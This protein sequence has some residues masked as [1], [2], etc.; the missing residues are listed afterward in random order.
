MKSADPRRNHLLGL[1]FAFGAGVC[2]SL[3]GWLIKSVSWNPMAI[4]GGRSIIAILLILVVLG[5]PKIT[6]S[7][8]QIGGALA[9]AATVIL[10]VAANKLTTAANAILLQYTGPIYTAFFGAKI[11]GERVNRSDW[12]AVVLV[13][14][15]VM[16]FFLDRLTL[17]GMAGNI[18]ALISGLSF[19]L[20]AV[21]LRQQKDESGLESVLL[22]NLV[23]ALM[24]LPF[25]VGGLP[26]GR[27]L[28]HLL[29]LGV[30]QLGLSYILYTEALKR[31][32]A[33]ESI[34]VAS[35]EPILN[36]LWVFLALGERPGPWALLGG[37]VVLITV[38][39]RS[40]LRATR[41]EA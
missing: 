7:R 30:F 24:G 22:G 29:L 6:W 36:P 34:L 35:I 3:G 40:L 12:L 16:L 4:S 33:L 28:F 13:L 9:Y 5:K 27:S 1:T 17:G 2:W 32:K 14:F 38:T 25:M 21:F 37:T 8:A 20:L 23:A 31:I 11:L 41:K 26:D 15:G 19:G 10:F 18:L 39:V